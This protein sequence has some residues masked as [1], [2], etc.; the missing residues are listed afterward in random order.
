MIQSQSVNAHTISNLYAFNYPSLADM[1]CYIA[2]NI[3][4]QCWWLGSGRSEDL[5]GL[6][7]G[8]GRNSVVAFRRSNRSKRV[9]RNLPGMK[10][11]NKALCRT[12]PFVKPCKEFRSN[13]NK[14]K[15]VKF[16]KALGTVLE[17]ENGPPP[18]APPSKG[19]YWGPTGWMPKASRG[20]EGPPGP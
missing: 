10:P 4:R 15:S 16:N 13:F 14:K 7:R 6:E 20:S 18:L 3:Y 19:G 2:M 17:K 12:C 5:Q 1:I 11:C 8:Q 9:K